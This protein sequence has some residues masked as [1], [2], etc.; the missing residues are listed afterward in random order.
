[1]RKGVV[2]LNARQ[3]ES[4]VDLAINLDYKELTKEEK[5]AINTLLNL[6]RLRL[7][8]YTVDV[9]ATSIAM[10]DNE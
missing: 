8:D 4:K 3:K 2:S 10:H 1:M 6:L 7:K 5:D 9:V